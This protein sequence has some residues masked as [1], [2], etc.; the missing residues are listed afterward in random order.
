[1]H[2]KMANNVIFQLAGEW[3]FGGKISRDHT[4]EDFERVFM[5][6]RCYCFLVLPFR[7]PSII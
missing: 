6:M 2:R 4:E 5:R 7:V 3:L 1:M